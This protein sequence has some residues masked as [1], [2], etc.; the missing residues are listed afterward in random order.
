MNLHAASP[1]VIIFSRCILANDL[2]A[3]ADEIADL[4]KTRWQI[5]L[6]FR[7]IKQILRIT[8]GRSENAVRI[9]IAVALIAHLILHMLQ[10]ITKV[11]HGS[12]E[13]VRLVR[14]I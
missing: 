6:F 13:L 7:L 10:Q 11:K 5:E 9:Q 4:C 1:A 2:D 12:L 3:P 14:T 8:M